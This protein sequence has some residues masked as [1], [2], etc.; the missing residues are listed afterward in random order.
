MYEVYLESWL[1]EASCADWHAGKDEFIEKALQLSGICVPA[2]SRKGRKEVTA[3][4]SHLMGRCPRVRNYDA[5]IVPWVQNPT[6][7][8]TALEI[9]TDS[10]L[11]ANW[12]VGR[13]KVTGHYL[14][15]VA[16]FH[17]LLQ[18]SWQTGQVFPRLPWMDFVRHIYR[19]RNDLADEAAK[20]SPLT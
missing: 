5:T 8:R 3:Y 14:Q 11:V 19:E 6:G 10:E 18:S 12:L 15:R 20:R 4:T 16:S 7:H 2:L 13:T 9:L 1:S 17:N